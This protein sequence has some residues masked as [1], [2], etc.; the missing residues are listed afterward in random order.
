MPESRWND[1]PGVTITPSIPSFGKVM[2]RR[3][4]HSCPRYSLPT[5][6]EIGVLPKV[7]T[8]IVRP[9]GPLLLGMEISCLTSNVS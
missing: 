9:E 2:S 1:G 7:S 5:F 4:F 6:S 8:T 3:P